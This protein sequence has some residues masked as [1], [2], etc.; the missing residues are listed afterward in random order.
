MHLKELNFGGVKVYFETPAQDFKLKKA[1]LKKI[2]VLILNAQLLNLMVIYYKRDVRSRRLF[3]DKR[4]SDVIDSHLLL[5]Q[6]IL[7]SAK[8]LKLLIIKLL[9]EGV[10]IL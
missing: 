6:C 1:S 7:I 4:G 2:I 9:A 5:L 8:T 10:G 3:I